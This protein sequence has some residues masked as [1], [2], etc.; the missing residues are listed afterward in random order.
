MRR[1]TVFAL[2]MA[3]DA[4]YAVNQGV[5][6]DGTDYLQELII[7]AA[8]LVS[9]DTGIDVYHETHRGRC[10]YSAPITKLYFDAI[11]ELKISADFSHWCC[12]S[13]SLLEGQEDVMDDAIKRT[14][15]IHAR[16]GNS[17]GPQVN[18]PFAPENRAALEAH[19]DW[20]QRIIYHQKSMGAKT[21]SITTEFGPVPYMQTLP[22]TNQVVA[23]VF[24]INTGMKSFLKQNL[25]T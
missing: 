3:Q 21:F 24:E 8:D 5:L 22:F 7:E 25:K 23:D 2:A 9:K 6:E 12:V 20:W 4:G 17:Q 13:E 18:H 19:L 11:P 14:G 15:H 16:V 1:L 10:L